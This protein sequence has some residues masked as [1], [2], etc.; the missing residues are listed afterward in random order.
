MD[1]QSGWNPADG[2]AETLK[3]RE[4]D[5]QELRTYTACSFLLL[6]AI[7]GGLALCRLVERSKREEM[8]RVLIILFSFIAGLALFDWT[9]ISILSEQDPAIPGAKDSDWLWGV[10]LFFMALGLLTAWLR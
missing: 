1:S 8:S 7:R 3:G 4:A 10:S 2:S 9:V 5:V 6:R